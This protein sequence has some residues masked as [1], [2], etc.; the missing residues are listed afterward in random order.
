VKRGRVAAI[1]IGTNSIRCIVVETA[2]AGKFKILDD[3]KVNVRL[4][5][6]LAAGNS[7]SP[8]AWHRAIDALYRIGKIIEGY[9]VAGVEAVATSAVRMA[10]NG[11]AFIA[12][13]RE[14]VGVE[15]EVIP[16]ETEAE[17]AVLSV[18]NN[19]EMPNNRFAVA[20]IG[21]GS[22]EIAT[23]LGNHIEQL[24]SLDLGAVLLTEKFQHSDPTAANEYRNMRKHVR[25]GLKTEFPDGAPPVPFLVGSGGTMTSVAAMTMAIRGEQ[26]GSVHGYEVLRSEVVHLLAM[27][28]R[29]DLKGRKGVPG[30]N[31]D[32]ADIIVAGVTVV[33]ELM[34]FFGTNLLKI[35]ERG[36]REGLILRALRRHGL[37]Q[38]AAGPV[39]WRDSVLEFARS[40]H[41]DEGHSMQ[42][43]KLSLQLFDALAPDAALG[44][45]QRQLLEA[46]AILHDVGYLISYAGHHKHSY[47]LIRHADL[48]GFTPRERELI[49]NI[50]RYHRK[51][52]PR[53]KHDTFTRLSPD[54]REMVSRLAAILRLADGLDRRRNGAVE[55]LDCTSSPGTVTITLNGETDL[56]VELFGGKAKGDLF[57]TSF[58]RKLILMADTGGGCAC[59]SA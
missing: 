47:H 37:Q 2:P 4:G 48:I 34:D 28:V 27:L 33:D 21:G 56:S 23:A 15:I 16:G 58:G 9:Q 43:A 17:L 7:I 10:T 8:A 3:E 36:I 24:S 30:L 51:S 39:T 52:V 29:K 1:D 45:K 26:Y 25:R 53:K 6:G 59:A 13:V 57:E 54:D 55:R 20:D 14:R 11:E 40:C 49:A 41:F 32:R 50:A 42:V 18:L 35:N 44:E 19:F 38:A 5:E 31:P 22:V 12:A 46:A